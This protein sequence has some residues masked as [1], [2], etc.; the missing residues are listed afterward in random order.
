MIKKLRFK[1]ILYTMVSI[2]SLMLVILLVVNITNF[3]L[4]GNDA[5]KVTLN[6]ANND[7]RFRP[8]NFDE[9]NIPPED[10]DRTSPNPGTRENN[11][12]AE[13]ITRYISVIYN[14]DTGE[15]RI[16]LERN[17][18][19]N[20]AEEVKAVISKLKGE[21][22]WY[23]NYRYRITNKDSSTTLYVLLDYRSELVP[24]QNVLRVSIIVFSTGIVLSLAIIIPT[25]RFFVRPL[26]TNYHRQKR[27]ITDASH[28]LKT[29]IT[30]ISANNE[31]EIVEKGE[32]D[33]TKAISNQVARL[34][35]LVKALND[36]SI[37]DEEEKAIG[38]EFNLT[39][40]TVD[41][42]NQFEK[43]F[44]QAKKE[45]KVNIDNEIIY[46]GNEKEIRELEVILLDN[47]LKYSK[48][49]TNFNLNKV[50]NRVV[51]IVENDTSN[52]YPERYN[53]DLQLVFERFYRGDEA[54]GST[55]SGNGIGLAIA[56]GIVEKH[57]GRIYA[58]G[59]GNIFIIRAEL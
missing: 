27:F 55:I 49:Y 57:K 3:S 40:A 53:G 36:L 17:S 46:N 25:S 13:A 6:I 26:E 21:V 18:T 50:G 16:N 24:S 47:A 44:K 58:N 34:T 5:D 51:L 11:P 28:E 10:I 37:I 42:C 41:I 1:F 33:A 38:S 14:R 4:V 48:S 54:R 19:Y 12:E 45:L 15:Y 7:G 9:N 43:S 59:K 35:T 8:A 32:S 52:N 31:I 22:G 30:I 29:P 2:F 23:K 56:K 20:N 39:N